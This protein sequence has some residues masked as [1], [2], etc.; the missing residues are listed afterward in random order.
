MTR[1]PPVAAH[2]TTHTTTD[3]ERQ[4]LGGEGESEG[5]AWKAWGPYLSDRAWGSVRE[6]FSE[7]GNAWRSFPHDHARS[8][9]FR[10]G[11]DGIA[12]ISDRDQL[13]CFSLALWNGRDPI[14]KE[15]F[16]GLDNGEGNHG[17]DVKEYYFYTDATPTHSLMRMVYQYPQTAF[18]YDTLVA[19]NRT[20]SKLETEYE[21][22]DTGA[23]SD[24]RYFSIEVA[25]AKAAVDDIAITITIANRG[26]AAATLDVLPTLWFRNTWSWGPD[27]QVGTGRKPQLQAQPGGIIAAQHELLGD[28]QLLCDHGPDGALPELLFCENDSNRQRL[29]G[30]P[31]QSPYVKDGINAYIVDGETTAV[32]PQAHGTKAAARYH[33]TVPAGGS[34]T[35]RLRLRRSSATPAFTDHA[36]LFTTRQ[37]EADAFYNHL[38]PAGISDD[39]KLIQR[40]AWAGMLWSKQWFSY[41]VP[42]WTRQESEDGKQH[43]RLLRNQ[44][45]HHFCAAD[46]MSMPDKWEYPWFAAWDLAYHCI[47]LA[48]I[49]PQFAKQQ[50]LLLVST[51]FQGANGAVPAYE[52]N[53]DDC[54]PP[55][56]A[57]AVRRVYHIDRQRT[58][59]ADREFLD[60]MFQRLGTY[61]VWWLN[62]KDATGCNLFQGGFLGLDNIGVFDRSK[63]L[64]TGGHIEQSDGT[65]W[66][67][68]F[69]LD[70]AL[71]GLELTDGASG[72]SE[73]T[74][75]YLE[76]FL[77][78]AVAMNNIGG[79]LSGKGVDLW[80]ADDGF[81]YDVLRIK[82]RKIPLKVR[83]LVGLIPLFATAIW[84]K[85]TFDRLQV[86]QKFAP[87]LATRPRLQQ[88]IESLLLVPPHSGPMLCSLV[89]QTK[90]EAL[91]KRMLD[92]DEFLSPYGI[93]GLSKFHEREPYTFFVDQT[94][95]SVRYVP[96]DSD[97][98]LFGGN[99]NWCGPV[100]LPVNYLLIT[101]L[102]RWFLHLGPDYLVEFPSGSGTRMHLGDVADALAVRL[103]N[104][105]AK[106]AAG[107]RP[108]LGSN[109]LFQHDPH[110]RDLLPFHEYFHGDN[111]TG[112]GASH[113][114][115]WTGLIAVLIQEL[116]TADIIPQP[117]A[118]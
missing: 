88:A 40:Q 5:E 2:N 117:G 93:R 11:E 62:R 39:Y 78:L 22:V 28:W 6:D 42:A 103:I 71:I 49:D 86:L 83:S 7:T 21:L 70:M 24:Q 89:G 10:W 112:L 3:P 113:Q 17:E 84:P 76:H 106:D 59:T 81:F 107:R 29:W 50:L 116:G 101:T 14:L 33:L 109:A 44:N 64:P 13:L 92:E 53:F 95:Y 115:G 98:F 54:N 34:I 8:R 38:H 46:I 4:R 108:A 100:W 110:W 69:C 104:L 72:H 1:T 18:P 20:R 97:T 85:G 12:G 9:A 23:F 114:T 111:G 73:M 75:G 27:R 36:Q 25:Y 99:S 118:R 19:T 87:I 41:D 31:N 57:R 82:E 58:G 105:L 68:V 63:P 96:G 94:P 79:N 56:I 74:L 37:H 43:E 102:K 61:Y 51:R 47:A 65:A 30:R 16:F 52:W 67:G 55:V 91:L 60:T 66:M 35:V 48:Y 45:W 32:N 90:F 80:D 77:Y 15:R 26:D